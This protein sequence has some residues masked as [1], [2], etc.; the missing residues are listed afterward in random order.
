MSLPGPYPARTEREPG[1]WARQFVNGIETYSPKHQPPPV[2]GGGRSTMTVLLRRGE[3]RETPQLCSIST[4]ADSILREVFD[5]RERC[6]SVLD[7]GL[8]MNFPAVG[9]RIEP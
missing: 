3:P 4:A 2:K 5:E 8:P 9:I 1:A 7:D 6:P